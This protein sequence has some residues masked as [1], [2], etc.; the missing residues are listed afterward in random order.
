MRRYWINKQAV[1]GHGIGAEV[2]IA[3]DELHHIRDVC[4]QGLGSKFEVIV[5]GEG[6][7]FVEITSESKKESR[8]RVLE[9]RAIPD[10]PRPHLHLAMSVPRF[11]VFEAVLEKAVELGVSSVRPFF[12][13][14]SFIKKQEDVFAKKL[15]R[16]EKIVVSSTQQCGRGELMPIHQP[17]A[18]E[19]LLQTF[20]REPDAV[21]LFAY[22]ASDRPG[23]LAAR[24]GLAH[25]HPLEPHANGAGTP[26]DVWIFVGA[27]GGFSD[28]EVDLFQSL[29][30]QPVTLGRQVLRVETACVALVSVIKYDFDLMR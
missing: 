7:Y 18:V 25:L 23:V 12:S 24:E 14:F 27:E 10:L 9:V 3:G 30:L 22:E 4:R 19:S 28:R 5:P 6:A 20:N 21:G 11:P 13:D 2:V 1:H 29:G 8:A 26:Q 16:F 15:P 17:I